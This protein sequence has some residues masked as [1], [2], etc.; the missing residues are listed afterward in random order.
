MFF[1]LGN[2]MHARLAASPPNLVR[3]LYAGQCVASHGME[4]KSHVSW[5][6]ADAQLA[7]FDDELAVVLPEGQAKLKWFRPPYGQRSAALVKKLEGQGIGTMLW[8]IDSQDWQH[9]VSPAAAGDRV[10]TLM[11]LWRHGVVLFHDVHEKAAGAL[12]RLFSTFDASGVVW[13]DCRAQ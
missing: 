10:A 12:P 8:N 1:T 2:A 4:H 13:A 11:L 7:I 3:A 9:A 6:E 5:K